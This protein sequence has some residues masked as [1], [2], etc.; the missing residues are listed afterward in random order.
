MV[1]R[2]A[3]G[4][5]HCLRIMNTMADSKDAIPLCKKEKGEYNLVNHLYYQQIVN[6]GTINQ[7]QNSITFAR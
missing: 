7:T 1:S 2:T 5:A 4:F 3:P 6:T